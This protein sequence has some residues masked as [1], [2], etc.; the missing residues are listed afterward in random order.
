MSNLGERTSH[1]LLHSPSPPLWNRVPEFRGPKVY[2][3]DAEQIHILDVPC[4][5][6]SPHSKVQIRSVDSRKALV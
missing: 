4:K 2:I 6:S 5:C 1:G 3:I